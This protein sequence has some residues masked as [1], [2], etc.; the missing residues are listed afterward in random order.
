MDFGLVVT[1]FLERLNL[2]SPN[3]KSQNNDNTIKE[4]CKNLVTHLI[5]ES[6]YINSVAMKTTNNRIQNF[7]KKLQIALL[8]LFSLRD[9]QST[10]LKMIALS[11]ILSIIHTT[12]YSYSDL[13]IT[14]LILVIQDNI[15]NDLFSLIQ[16]FDGKKKHLFVTN[17]KKKEEKNSVKEIGVP[18][19]SFEQEKETNFEKTIRSKETAISILPI[20]IKY[21]SQKQ[22]SQFSSNIFNTILFLVENPNNYILANFETNM[23]ADLI[24]II[25][26]YIKPSQFYKIISILKKNLS[27][28]DRQVQRYCGKTLIIFFKWCYVKQ[29]IHKKQIPIGKQSER[30]K[31]IKGEEKIQEIEKEKTDP[32]KEKE[33]EEK[34]DQEIEKQEEEKTDKEKEKQEEEKTDKEK[35]KE[36]KEK[37]NQEIQKKQKKKKKR[38]LGIECLEFLF[39]YKLKIHTIAKKA[40]ILKKNNNHFSRSQLGILKTINFLIE[41]FETN[42]KYLKILTKVYNYLLFYYLQPIKL[43]FNQHLISNSLETLLKVISKGGRYKQIKTLIKPNLILLLLQYLFDGDGNEKTSISIKII[44][45]NLLNKIFQ[46]RPKLIFQICLLNNCNCNYNLTKLNNENQKLIKIDF[47][48]INIGIIKEN[49]IIKLLNGNQDLQIEK[50]IVEFI[51]SLLNFFLK[52]SN[53]T[54]FDLNWFFQLI[55]QKL[56]NDILFLKQICFGYSN[57]LIDLENYPKFQN[58][59]KIII[60]KL[61]EYLDESRVG[62]IIKLDIIQLITKYIIFYPKSNMNKTLIKKLFKISFDFKDQRIKL[63]SSKSLGLI[64]NNSNKNQNK[65]KNKNKTKNKNKNI[66]KNKTNDNNKNRNTNMNTNTNT[67]KNKKKKKQEQEHK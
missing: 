6:Q 53:K 2:I 15:K 43:Q 1:P 20:L 52:K 24:K 4:S 32:E 50:S 48:E 34:T 19:A 60:Y 7:P 61:I 36:E 37:E 12:K 9:D 57:Y 44:V 3:T 41:D 54:N 22:V 14:S 23:F 63:Q 28:S 33:E 51:F 13:I 26:S 62:W 59:S 42:P 25:S 21:L 16:N 45:I 30:K 11:S 55:D 38:N 8:I 35:E 18:I 64:C 46:L 39:D 66:N 49:Q 27:H 58:Q 31:D 40:Q 10:N 29:K 67:N 17:D 47:N 65:N 5:G 56:K